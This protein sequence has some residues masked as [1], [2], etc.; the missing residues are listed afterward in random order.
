MATEPPMQRV[1]V[2]GISGAGKTTMARRLAQLL[3][4]PFH[5]LDALHHGPGWQ[6]RPEFEAD[7]DAFTSA[8]RWVTDG[9]YASQL[10]DVLWERADTVVWLDMSR[11][12]VMRRVIVRTLVRL[13]RRTPLWNGNRERWR[14]LLRADHPIHWAWSQHARRRS[15][16]AQLV[17]R[18]PGV[19]VV[20]L[21]TPA[22][23]A[24]WLRGI[25]PQHPAGR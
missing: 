14:D 24:G 16:I 21:R 1:L 23:A 5:E 25:R 9:H 19:R 22:Q 3:A 8:D 7:V 2:A 20:R 17:E 12:V 10:G 15:S 6:R 13:L 11:A 18:H 4:L